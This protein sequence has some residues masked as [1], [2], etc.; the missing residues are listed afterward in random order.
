MKYN[1]EVKYNGVYDPAGTEVPNEE[2]NGGGKKAPAVEVSGKVD[3][4]EEKVEPVEEV[5]ESDTT[6]KYTEE[7]L[8]VSIQQL[9][10]LAKDN[11]LKF[12]NRDKSDD[13]REMLRAL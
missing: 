3:V 13:L 9:R 12:T 11:G 6:H 5:A 2:T 1:H 7:D 8:N 4:V 10:K